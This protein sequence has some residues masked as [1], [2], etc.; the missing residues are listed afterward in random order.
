[1]IRNVVF[2]WSGTLAD[3]L[4]AVL[5]AVNGVFEDHGLPQWT[6]EEFLRRFRLPFTEFYEE[7][8]P[9]IPLAQVA[10]SYL[11]HFPAG[12]PVPALPHAEELLGELRGAGVRMVVL[13][14]APEVHVV[15][16][17]KQLGW[18]E[19]FE[20]FHCGVVDK[21]AHL[22]KLLQ[23]LDMEPGQTVMVGDMRH[24]VAAGKAAGAVAA[25]VC[26]GY[27]SAELLRTA[28]PD[29]M[30]ADLSALRRLLG[31][32][33]GA[34]AEVA[35]VATVGALIREA[36][37]RLLMIQTHKWKHKWGIP[38][39]KIQRGEACE[40]A[41]RREIREETGLE[42]T[43]VRF[44]MVQDCVEPPEFMRS[45]HFLLLNYVADCAGSLPEVRLNEEAQRWR[46]V[47]L[48]EAGAL[49]LN[50]PTR[51]LLEECRNRGMLQA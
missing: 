24:D 38:G 9:Q 6:K 11:R 30:L 1:M 16:Q 32:G 23:A 5:V 36:G 31:R 14:S 7:V 20:Q 29:V 44:V 13:S 50:E 46:W 25:A 17:A 21:V 51:V 15:E 8:M 18:M 42:L 28:E 34:A 37:G 27:E 48:E 45:A 47:T 41:L 4:P 49:D 35:P 10:L 26:G 3:D 19:F 43:E 39:G 33:R 2:D 40:A 22:P 12:Q